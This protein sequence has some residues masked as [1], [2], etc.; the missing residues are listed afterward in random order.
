M[1][2]DFLGVM[3][4]AVCDESAGA[5]QF[6][7]HVSFADGHCW[8]TKSGEEM[9][10]DP[11]VLVDDDGRYC[12]VYSSRHNHEQ[13][14]HRSIN[15][16]ASWLTEQAL[17]EIY[18]KP[19]EIA[20]KTGESRGLMTSFNRIG[21]RWTGDAAQALLVITCIVNSINCIWVAVAGRYVPDFIYNIGTTVLNGG[22]SMVIFFFVDR[23]IFPESKR[24]KAAG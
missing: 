15:G 4:V 24:E 2:I 17:R 9:P 11:G 21:T 7:G 20:V 12:L 19:F 5:Y 16:D 10:F 1:S 13:E 14:T 8:G 22:V 3:G 18:L 6:Y 23:I